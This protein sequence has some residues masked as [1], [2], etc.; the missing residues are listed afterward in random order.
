MPKRGLGVFERS[1][2]LHIGADCPSKNL[3]FDESPRDLEFVRNRIDAPFHEIRRF[4]GYLLTLARPFA[5]R[6]KEKSVRSG[7][8]TNASPN[9]DDRLYQIWNWNECPAIGRLDSVRLQFP[10][11]CRV[12]D[13]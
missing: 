4:E 8:F 11:E 3:K 13:G 6:C 1:M 7:V 5:L 10:F 9:L 12:F 2:E